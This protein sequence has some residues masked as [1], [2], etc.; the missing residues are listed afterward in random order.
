MNIQ[1]YVLRKF[2]DM[3]NMEDEMKN[4]KKRFEPPVKIE[5]FPEDDVQETIWE[6]M[7]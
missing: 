4:E 3:G 5:I 7:Y 1:Y 6:I 2:L